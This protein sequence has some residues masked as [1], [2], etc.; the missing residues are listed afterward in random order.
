[1]RVG[2]F[3]ARSTAVGVLYPAYASFKAIESHKTDDDVSACSLD[4]LC[5]RGGG[6]T[7]EKP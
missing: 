3:R 5:S 4:P 2:T 1:M 6:G 7:A